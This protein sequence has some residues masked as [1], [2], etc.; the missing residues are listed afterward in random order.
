VAYV[1]GFDE[2]ANH[3]TYRVEWSPDL[4]E[5]VGRCLEFKGLY[6]SAPTAQQAIARTEQEVNEHIRGMDYQFGAAPRPLTEHNYSGR[7]VVRTSRTLHARLAIEA[8]EQGVSLNQ[9]VVQKLAD[10]PST[11]DW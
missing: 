8:A 10:R 6:G 9:W 11:L 2:T 5:Y 1:G 3:Y 7:F 4:G